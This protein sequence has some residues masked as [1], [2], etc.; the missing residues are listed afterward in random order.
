MWILM[1]FEV[2]ASTYDFDQLIKLG[3]FRLLNY[4]NRNYKILYFLLLF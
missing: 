3:Y 1:N 2:L 4:S